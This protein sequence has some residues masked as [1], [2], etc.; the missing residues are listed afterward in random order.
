V[1]VVIGIIAAITMVSYSGINNKAIIAS[2]K[3]NLANDAQLLK[4]YHTE[5]GFYPSSLDGNYCPSSPVANTTY[6]LKASAG[7]T[8]T[9]SGG[10]SSF[11]VIATKNGISYYITDS[12]AVAALTAPI[13]DYNTVTSITSTTATIGA[14]VVSDGGATLTDAGMCWGTTANPTTNCVSSMGN[15]GMLTPFATPTIAAGTD[16]QEGVD[17]SPDGTSVY[18]VNYL[19]N[20]ISMYSRDISTGALTALATPTISTGS[21]PVDIVVSPDGTSVYVTNYSSDTISMYSRNTSTGALTALATPTIAAGSNPYNIVISP[22][23]TSVYAINNG[24]NNVSMYSRN[25]STGL[26]S[27]LSTPTVAAGNQTYGVAISSD[28]KS[29]YALNYGADNVSMYSR[30]TGSIS[31]GVAFTQARTGLPS[32]STIHYRGYTTNSVGTGYSSDSTFTTQ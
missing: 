11:K 5:N 13:V 4:M 7:T 18:V 2:L 12:S 28:G 16:P 32:G 14:T 30:N 27:A 19:S 9:Y 10:G 1:I 22:D 3:F 26:L 24:S 29:V 17:V 25:T 8:L 21:R 31:I 15:L 20:N 23:G 6:C